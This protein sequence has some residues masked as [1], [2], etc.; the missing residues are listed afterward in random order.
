MSALVV[1][2]LSAVSR[3]VLGVYRGVLIW[4][5]HGMSNVVV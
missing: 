1:Q 2:L 3:E 5:P 4:R